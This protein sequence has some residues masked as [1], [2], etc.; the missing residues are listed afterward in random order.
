MRYQCLIDTKAKAFKHAL[1]VK[2]DLERWGKR[3]AVKVDGVWEGVGDYEIV[4]TDDLT[5]QAA[6]YPVTI[7]ASFGELVVQARTIDFDLV[8][9][10]NEVLQKFLAMD[11]EVQK[12]ILSKSADFAAEIAKVVG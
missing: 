3:E 6:D 11:M 7:K 1:P 2:A 8:P 12:S 4:E 9:S 5:T 10:I